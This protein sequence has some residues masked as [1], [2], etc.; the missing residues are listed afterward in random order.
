MADKPVEVV[1]GLP[2][3][4]AAAVFRDTLQ[5]VHD[6]MGWLARSK[7]RMAFGPLT[8]ARDV[9]ASV[10]GRAEPSFSA[11]A[12]IEHKAADPQHVQVVI[13]DQGSERLVLINPVSAPLVS[14]LTRKTYVE[15]LVA[16][17]KAA[18]PRATVRA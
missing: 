18:D 12:T 5:G 13:Y 10:D 2:V 17:Y 6:S 16:A 7:R 9:F 1:T 4:R 15:P 3:D 14:R 11:V 8:V